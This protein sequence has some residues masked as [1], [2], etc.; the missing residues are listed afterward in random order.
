M[1]TSERELL[2]QLNNGDSRALALLFRLYYKD[3]VL[4]AGTWLSGNQ[5][6]CEDIVQE[7]FMS[8]WNERKEVLKIKALKSFLLK[9]VQNRCISCLRHQQVKGKYED[10]KSY[11]DD[12]L[13]YDTEN[14]ILYS[15][16]NARLQ[17][18]L[19]YL[20]PVQRQC[21]EMNRMD[22]IRQAEIAKIL[23]IP[24]RTV[25]LRIA[26]ALKI[27]KFHLKEY[28]ILVCLFLLR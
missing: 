9:S 27:L 10:L 8:L 12:R 16:L 23:G 25:E 2:Q 6:L 15:E 28:F 11:T 3:L 20:S 21:F 1:S 7:V 24:L 13:S 19:G 5:M 26:E 22:G 18:A 17:E 14:Y 4:F